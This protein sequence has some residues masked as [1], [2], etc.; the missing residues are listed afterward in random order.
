[1]RCAWARTV[2]S[3]HTTSVLWRLEQMFS[4]VNGVPGKSVVRN[5]TYKV[6][7]SIMHAWIYSRSA[8]FADD[9]PPRRVPRVADM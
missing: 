6:S 1:M 8:F 7:L 5:S 4:R 3:D 9:D 2:R